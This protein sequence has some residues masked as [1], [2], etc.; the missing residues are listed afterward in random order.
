MKKV[1]F[2]LLVVFLSGCTQKVWLIPS[3]KDQSDL[4]R[5][6]R[7]CL[8]EAQLATPPSGA[9]VDSLGPRDRYGLWAAALTGVLQAIDEGLRVTRLFGFCME[10]RGYTLIDKPQP[11][12]VV[13]PPVVRSTV[14]P[15][16]QPEAN[17]NSPELTKI[18]VETE[19]VNPGSIAGRDEA[20]RQRLRQRGLLSE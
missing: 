15:I 8:Y 13:Q 10:A 19:N 14:Q 6:K 16:A 4:E 17:V 5:D 1:L 3:E 2:I 7:E 11:Q 18:P 9:H 12:V 20:W